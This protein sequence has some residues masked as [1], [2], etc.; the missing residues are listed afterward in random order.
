M[1]DSGQRANRSTVRLVGRVWP[2]GLDD[3]DIYRIEDMADVFDGR[4]MTRR[5]VFP[6]FLKQLC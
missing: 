3:P 4:K 1:S 5:P 2:A 6:E